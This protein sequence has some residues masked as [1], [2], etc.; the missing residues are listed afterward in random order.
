M[1]QTKSKTWICEHL[2][3]REMFSQLIAI[4]WLLIYIKEHRQKRR[5]LPYCPIQLSGRPLLTSIRKILLFC[6]RVSL[7]SRT[8]V[9]SAVVFWRRIQPIAAHNPNSRETNFVLDRCL[10]PP[11]PP[12]SP[13]ICHT[14]CLLLSVLLSICSTHW[15]S[16]LHLKDLHLGFGCLRGRVSFVQ[17]RMQTCDHSR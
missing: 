6:R 12:F 15:H 16:R 2:S 8:L 14:D 9:I 10:S 5:P 17:R 4:S 7:S 13:S 1:I 3:K 11:P